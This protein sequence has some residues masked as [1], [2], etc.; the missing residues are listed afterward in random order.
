MVAA[1]IGN[2]L[3]VSRLTWAWAR[4][5][6]LPK[7]FAMVDGKTRIPMRAVSGT[8]F[9]IALLSFLFLN[10][11]AF[12]ALGAIGSLSS[13]SLYVSY[14]IGL[15]CIIY[16]RL[17]NSSDLQRGDW[18]CGKFGLPINIFA[19]LYTIWEVI[20]LP[21][22]NAL[23][24]TGANMNYAGPVYMAV[25]VMAVSYWFLWARKHWE[26]PN[27]KVVEIVLQNEEDPK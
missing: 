18:S 10:D 1:S 25:L 6:G 16:F 2:L 13:M 14:I 27:M 24:V 5:G 15:G 21:F 20:W 9:I 7:Y 11:H 19:L 8:A 12:I 3:S 26:G 17:A 22:P 4:D 23:P